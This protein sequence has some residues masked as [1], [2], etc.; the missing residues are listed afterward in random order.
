[1]PFDFLVGFGIEYFDGGAPAFE[2]TRDEAHAPEESEN[3][4]RGRS[5]RRPSRLRG[6]MTG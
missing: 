5:S 4:V 1:M 2:S 3:C 6:T